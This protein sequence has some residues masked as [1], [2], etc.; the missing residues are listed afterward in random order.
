MTKKLKGKV[1]KGWGHEYIWIT[2]D[3]YCSKFM[4]FKNKGSKFSMHFHKE[5][6][7]TWFVQSGS[8][9]LKYLDTSNAKINE[10][11]LKTGDIWNNPPMLPH[12]LEALEENSTVIEVSTPDSIEDNFRIFPGDSQ[13]G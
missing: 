4:V 5:K 11:I 3:K 6:E 2:N 13:N 12:Q 9:L 8:F 1:K 7:E 10:K